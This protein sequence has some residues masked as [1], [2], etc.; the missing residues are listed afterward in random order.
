MK[1]IAI[2]KKMKRIAIILTIIITFG[3]KLTT[4]WADKD[5]ASSLNASILSFPPA[6]K[7]AGHGSFWAAL[8]SSYSNN[9][10]CF[11]TLKTSYIPAKGGV[12]SEYGRVNFKKG[13][14]L[15]IWTLNGAFSLGKGVIRLDYYRLDSNPAK[16]RTF[17]LK[18]KIEG[19]TF[20]IG[21]G[22]PIND[23]LS[24]GITWSPLYSSDVK[25][26]L[27]NLNVAKGKSRSQWYR[28]FGLG[29][30]YQPYKWLSLGLSYGH[31]KS[32]LK[33]TYSSL[34]DDKRTVDYPITNLVRPGLVIQPKLGTIIGVDWLWGQID[35]ERG[36]KYTFHQWYFGLEQYFNPYFALRV[37]SADGSLTTGLGIRWKNLIFDYAYINQSAKDLK[38]YLGKSRAHL[39]TLTFYW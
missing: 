3:I 28:S 14:D 34:V 27:G 36:R 37:G 16:S 4:A 12:Y 23:K 39:Y 24:L 38:R 22:H 2:I 6:V 35:N 10:A 18:N 25:F 15:N 26:K 5:F 13:P 29:M 11:V 33:T 17:G 31:N 30:L 19:Q 7:I 20:Q 21:Y 9:P 1:G 32:K 8:P